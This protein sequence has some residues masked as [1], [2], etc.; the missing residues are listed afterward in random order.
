MGC[1]RLLQQCWKE[2]ARGGFFWG[3]CE[4]PS[5]EKQQLYGRDT[6]PMPVS[7][8]PR[9]Q[10]PGKGLAAARASSSPR[11]PPRQGRPQCAWQ[12]TAALWELEENLD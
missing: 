5:A 10:G 12:I 11:A 7:A 4:E 3:G 6:L 1:T 2:E 9:W 8:A